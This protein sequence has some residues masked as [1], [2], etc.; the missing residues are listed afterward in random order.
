M[1]LL[2]G[3]IVYAS[4]PRIGFRTLAS[5]GVPMEIQQAFIEYVVCRHWDT[6]NPP[7]S[8]YQAV[9]LYQV[10]PEHNLFGWL[11]ND[12]A[13]DIG[14]ND[15]PYFHCYYLGEP[16][17]D[18][19]LEII[20]TYLR[21][22][23]VALIDRHSSG[24][25]LETKVFLELWSY[26]PARLGVEISLGNRRRSHIAL[27]QGELLDLFVPL[28]DQEMVIE[29]EQTYDQ[30]MVN[31]SFYKRYIIEGIETDAANLNKDAVANITRVKNPYQDYKEKLQL[32]EQA[33]IEAIQHQYP[34]RD[35]TRNTLKRLQQVLGLTDKDI[36]SI[37]ARIAQQKKEHSSNQ[38]II[39]CACWSL[40]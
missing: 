32:Y 28:N 19:Q 37:E 20:F 10:T 29:L 22:G 30:P 38:S 18:F 40:K 21:Q 16:L 8:G 26:K 25:S 7:L 27:N 35:R 12:G 39:I 17:L 9:Y 6:Y 13:D 3:Q 36:E 33:L 1:D 14:R 23:P 24:S 34:P 15:V 5:A 11:Y 2:L 4:F 31:L